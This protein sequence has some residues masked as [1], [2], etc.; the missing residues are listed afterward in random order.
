MKFKFSTNIKKLYSENSRK[1]YSKLIFYTTL[2]ISVIIFTIS[3]I[4]YVNFKNILLSHIYS[5]SKDSFSQVG[6]IANLMVDTTKSL[7]VQLNFDA[8]IS[9]L[10]YYDHLETI[11]IQKALTK[12]NSYAASMP[13]VHSIYIY[14]GHTDNFYTTISS[15]GIQNSSTFFDQELVEILDRVNFDYAY[16]PIPRRLTEPNSYEGYKQTSNIYTF[17]FRP[18]GKADSA[19]IL[20]FSD[21]WIRKVIG[22]QDA[23]S[24]G[25]V[26]IVDTHGK[27]VG[28]SYR[29]EMLTDV[30]NEKYYKRII[31][32]KN[33]SGY[34]IDNADGRKALITYVYNEGL[35]WTF[36]KTVPYKIIFDKINII[37]TTTIT[38]FIIILLIGLLLSFILSRK[39]YH[40]IYDMDDKLNTLSVENRKNILQLKQDFFRTILKS[41]FPSLHQTIR[42]TFDDFNITLEPDS[43]IMII[44]LKIDHFSDFRNTY[45]CND[46]SLIK[47]GILNIAAE[48]CSPFFMNE[49]VDMDQDHVILVI[50]AEDCFTDPQQMELDSLIRDI[51]SKVQQY[52]NVSLSVTVSSKCSTIEEVKDIYD[53]T[54]NNSYYRLFQGHKCIIYSDKLKI[55]SDYS[56]PLQKEKQLTEALISG[57]LEEVQKVFEQIVNPALVEY[58]IT[59]FNN[60]LLR[61]AFSI[62]VALDTMTKSGGILLDFNFNIFLYELNDLE[63]LQ[64]IYAH[65]NKLFDMID[66]KLDEKKSSKYDELINRVIEIIFLN[67]A[68]QNLSLESIADK[69][70]LSATYLRRLFK[71]H[72]SKS[73]AD[74]I[75]DVRMEK[76]IELLSNTDLSINEIC[77]KSG[78]SSSNYFYSVFKKIHG[79]TPNEHR[80]RINSNR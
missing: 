51:Q 39:L 41:E 11:N 70:N 53:Q 63:L 47:F 60:T 72:T 44:L 30:S 37:M 58:P 10:M 54:L 67:Y 16:I 59:S 52:L 55:S 76:A 62:N 57:K 2:F 7:L 33:N 34:I 73:I 22:S 61:L 31:A 1:L 65:F 38:I 74:Y 17:V 68:D 5:S 66:E 49:T 23:D 35:Q 12:L 18:T 3:A 64:D 9:D 77:N 21:L 15:V 40:P 48:L 19:V 25:S 8:D 46:R 71:K 42:K 29:D 13:Y 4:Q 6:N 24:Q 80:Q 20:N 28:S 32:S 27:I 26:Y 43:P 14:N 75:N 69:I 78:F 50:E 56:Y 45:N 79:V 36:I